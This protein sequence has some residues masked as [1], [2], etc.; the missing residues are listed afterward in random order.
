MLHLESS[1]YCSEMK[2]STSAKRGH[3][4]EN[5]EDEIYS[6]CRSY[7]STKFLWLK[8]LE[9]AALDRWLFR[10]AILTIQPE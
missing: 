10:R 5:A 3:A 9:L 7:M 2:G 8:P 6:N 4:E 1:T